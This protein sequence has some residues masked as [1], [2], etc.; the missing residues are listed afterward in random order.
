MTLQEFLKDKDFLHFSRIPIYDGNQDDI[1]GYVL[2]DLIFEKLADDH[3][4]LKLK[5]IKREIITFPESITLFDAWDKL[6]SKKEHIALVVDKYGGMGGI[7]TIE[8]IIESLLGVEIVDEKDKVVDMQ[9]YAMERWKNKQKKYQ[10]LSENKV[11]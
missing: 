7:V 1:S 4:D 9:Q 3:F 8:D 5:D 11:Y 6:L 2:R 10:L